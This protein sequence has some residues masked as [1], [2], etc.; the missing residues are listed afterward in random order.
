MDLSLNVKYRLIGTVLLFCLWAVSSGQTVYSVTEEV[1]TGTVIGNV[2]KDLNLNVQ[3]LESRMFQIV[4]GTYSQYFKVDLKTG[5]LMV[6]DRIDR[7]E[8]CPDRLKC[9]VKIE[10]IAHGPT[11]MRQVDINVLDIN[12]NTPTFPVPSYSLNI[13][14]HAFQGDRFLLQVAGDADIGS[15]SV[16]TYRLSPNEYFSLDVQNSDEQGVSAELVLQKALDREKQ[17]EI[18]LILTAL[19]GGKPPKSGTLDITVHVIDFNDNAPTFR[20]SL[21]K[22]KL[23]E[24]ALFGTSVIT[25]N[26]TDDDE[27]QNAEIIYSLARQ[28]NVKRKQPFAIHPDSGVITVTGVVD[29]EETPAYEL[30]VQAMDKGNPPRVGHCKVLIEVVDL[31]DNTPEMSITPL[32][33]TLPEDAKLQTAVAMI[34]VSDRDAGKNGVVQCKITDSSLFK[35]ESSYN[36][37]LSLVVDG[38]LDRESTPQYNVT[39]TATDEGSPPLSSSG[40]FTIHISDV[41]DNAP[42][43]QE[44]VMNV[45]LKENSAVGDK[46]IQVTAQDADIKENADITY[47]LIDVNNNDKPLS[48][49]IS[50]N[51]ATGEIYSV[52][53]FNFEETKQFRFVIQAT[54][55]GTPA[56]SSSASMN[57]FILDENDNSPVILPPYSDQSSVN[58][59]NIPYS[60]EVGYFVAKIRAADADSGYNALLSYHLAEPKG[61]NLFRI[62]G[63]SGEIRTKRQ[64][65]DSDLK[66]HP[67]VITVSDHGEPPLSATVSIDVVVDDSISHIQ[68]SFKTRPIKDEEFSDL[69]LYLLIAII[70]V[71]VILLVSLITLI[72]VKCHRT[73]GIFSSCSAP[74]VTTHPDGS[75]AYA[76]T[77]QQYDVCFSSDT[78]KSDVIVLPSPFAPGEGDLISIDGGD[79]CKRT[80]TLPTPQKLII[81]NTTR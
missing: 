72:A 8:L 73:D 25:V 41:N 27:G 16:K 78:L 76:K 50:I 3:E 61:T 36:N 64:M 14:E 39:I 32:L 77:T 55:S 21:Y 15:N 58:S 4:P 7:D 35:L 26:A 45:Y 29:F 9:S 12:D 5:L 54:D 67:L 68:S 13:T 44:P 22:T 6:N 11:Y 79:T 70:L 66:T 60:A 51:S 48:N 57:I 20:N 71:T 74:M 31:N 52:K 49:C 42:T 65:S 69:N 23:L 56:L 75:W 24:N 80:Q 1:N 34:T 63:S 81:I 38:P 10:V 30:R 28:G 40:I 2:A 46:I 43:F 17:H 33:N 59:E 47:T 37:Y 18:Q 19:D 53:S 62:G